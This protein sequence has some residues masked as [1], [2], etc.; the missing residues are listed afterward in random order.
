MAEERDIWIEFIEKLEELTQDG[1]LR[2][3]SLRPPEILRKDPNKLV[4]IIFETEYK[5]RRL[6]LYEE[7]VN[8]G[9]SSL[10][11]IQ[12]ILTGKEASPWQD[13]IVLELLDKKG[14]IWEFPEIE[15]L[16][17]LLESVKFQVIGVN[18]YMEAVLADT[19]IP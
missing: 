6:R 15:G 10:D 9:R 7:K 16:D 3:T 19:S 13:E 14:A 18:E 4:S 2:W 1:T 12:S 5:E 11:G 8:V 17:D